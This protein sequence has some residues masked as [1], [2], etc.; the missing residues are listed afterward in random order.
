MREVFEET[1]VLLARDMD[2]RPLATGAPAM[3]TRLEDHRRALVL[4][5]RSF[6]AVLASEGWFADLAS[7]AYLA[8]S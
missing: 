2:G 1:G 3:V 6:T 8:A 4:G 7:L 5:E